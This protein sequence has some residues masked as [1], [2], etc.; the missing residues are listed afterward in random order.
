MLSVKKYR[1]KRNNL[2]RRNNSLGKKYKR[3]RMKKRKNKR[4]LRT[5]KRIR[6]RGGAPRKLPPKPLGNT[7]KTTESQTQAFNEVRRVNTRRAAKKSQVFEEKSRA[8]DAASAELFERY[9]ASQ[10]SSQPPRAQPEGQEQYDPIVGQF[11]DSAR[12]SKHHRN[13]RARQPNRSVSKRNHTQRTYEDR[14]DKAQR[15]ALTAA[16]EKSGIEAKETRRAADR[17]GK[18][19]V[20]GRAEYPGSASQAEETRQAADRRGKQMVRRGAEYPG[21]V[22]QVEQ[23][24]MPT[25]DEDDS[26]EEGIINRLKFRDGWDYY[27]IYGITGRTVEDPAP[28]TRDKRAVLGTHPDKEAAGLTSKQEEENAVRT[29]GILSAFKILTNPKAKEAYDVW[30]EFKE[31]SS[32]EAHHIAL[33]VL[34]EEIEEKM[35]S[36]RKLGG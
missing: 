35:D 10:A 36:E 27:D 8:A 26:S 25:Y 5:Q 6:K 22:S 14:S 24:R 31:E 1:V 19:M 30:L 13:P 15:R 29:A 4:I 33:G 23:S 9:H 32:E 28:S 17:R 2:S 12:V 21:S 3:S 34:D 20:I 18:Q 11:K 7:A 16:A